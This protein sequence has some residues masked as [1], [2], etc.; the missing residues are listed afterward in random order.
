MPVD[1]AQSALEAFLS[2][3]IDMKLVKRA[4]ELGG[5]DLAWFVREAVESAARA[6][7]DG[8]DRT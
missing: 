4:C 3:G 7:I 2:L 8:R 5:F 6:I 1:E